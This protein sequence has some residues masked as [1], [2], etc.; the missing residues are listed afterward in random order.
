MVS[1]RI[2]TTEGAN[3][4]Q[5]CGDGIRAV[6]PSNYGAFLRYSFRSSLRAQFRVEESWLSLCA[7]GVVNRTRKGVAFL[8]AVTLMTD[9]TSEPSERSVYQLDS[10]WVEDNGRALQL[11]RSRVT[12]SSWR[13]STPRAR[14]L[15]R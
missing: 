13:S 2:G 7:G 3:S 8:A 12:C 9:V 11:A 5:F 4:S 15:A 1:G 14:A 6:D 10:S